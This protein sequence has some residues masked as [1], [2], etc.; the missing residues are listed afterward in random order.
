[1]YQTSNSYR[2]QGCA[3]RKIFREPFGLPSILAGVSRPKRWSPKLINQWAVSWLLKNETN[4]FLN[5]SSRTLCYDFLC[6]W[7]ITSFDLLS[8]RKKEK[9]MLS[10][11]SNETH[12]SFRAVRIKG[13]PAEYFMF[14]N[15]KGVTGH[16]LLEILDRHALS[17]QNFCVTLR[18]KRPQCL[19][20][21]LG[22][23]T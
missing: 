23:K 4:H 6:S 15:G 21:L 7:K 10:Y 19:W 5:K 22:E 2:A 11:T 8:V 20:A 17:R 12:Q 14:L 1:M 18:Y 13:N 16:P 3:L 9:R